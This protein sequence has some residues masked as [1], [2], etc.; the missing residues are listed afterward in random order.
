MLA[1][2]PDGVLEHRWQR[3][4][5][6]SLWICALVAPLTLLTNPYVVLPQYAGLTA[7]IENPLAVPALEWAAPLVDTL[8][9]SALVF[10]PLSRCSC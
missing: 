3:V 2:F 8:V 7:Q 10:L 5:V 1:S 4:A 9:V 6:S